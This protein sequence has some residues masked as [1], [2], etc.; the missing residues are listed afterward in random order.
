MGNQRELNRRKY[1]T[2]EQAEGLEE[3]PRQLKPNEL[4]PVARA[5]FLRV[6]VTSITSE[7]ERSGYRTS[8]GPLWKS[9]LHRLNTEYFGIIAG[10]RAYPRRW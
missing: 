6:F 8:L 4:P 9:W 3:L 7:M 2:F 1:L 5:K 10:S